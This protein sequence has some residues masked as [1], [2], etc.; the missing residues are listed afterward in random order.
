MTGANQLGNG[1][2]TTDRSSPSRR[3]DYSKTG[4]PQTW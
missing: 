4:P 2:R 1:G 3:R